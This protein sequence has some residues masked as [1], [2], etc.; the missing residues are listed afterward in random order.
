M[1]KNLY[2]HVSYRFCMFFSCIFSYFLTCLTYSIKYILNRLFGILPFCSWGYWGT[3]VTLPSSRLRNSLQAD[4][5]ESF[6]CRIRPTV[7]LAIWVLLQI[8]CFYR[9]GTGAAYGVL[10]QVCVFAYRNQGSLWGGLT[11]FF[12]RRK[13]FFAAGPFFILGAS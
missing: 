9:S 13:I 2:F 6:L 3:F 5:S 8:C 7:I 1:L 11:E 10:L 12:L 4:V